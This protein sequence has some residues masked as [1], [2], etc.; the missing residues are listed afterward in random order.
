MR[1]FLTTLIVTI[2]L[3]YTILT[4]ALHLGGSL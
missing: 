4:V 2:V 3:M 1:D